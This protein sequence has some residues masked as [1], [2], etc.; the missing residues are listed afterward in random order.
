MTYKQRLEKQME[1]KVEHWVTKAFKI[2]AMIILG[3]LAF[4]LAVYVLMRLWNW[5][6]PD[7]FDLGTLNYWQ[8]LGLLV[9]AKLIFG[10]GG[11]GSHKSQSKSK[12][13]KRSKMNQ[14]CGSLRNDFSE[15]KLYDDFWAEEGEA[16]FKNYVDRKKGDDESA[17][18]EEG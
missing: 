5:L 10:F 7:L 9:L 1:Q 3:T 8:A 2:V 13:K 6:M 14:K 12:A 11:G 16:A 18:K 15:W 4:A 17:E